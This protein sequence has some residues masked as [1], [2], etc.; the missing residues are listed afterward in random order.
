MTLNI[1][2][3]RRDTPGC[4]GDLI[5]LNNAGA[6]LMPAPV[7]AAV[8]DHLDLEARIG[9]YE[10]IE[11]RDGAFRDV[12]AAIAAL[13]NGAPDEIALVHNATEAWNAGFY[14][15]PWQ[16]GD[17]VIT[18]T[19]DY[20]SNMIAFRQL[21][22][23]RGVEVILAPE[24]ADASIDLEALPRLI[25][26]K[27]RLIAISHMPTNDGLVQPVAEIG[28]IARA[29]QVPFLLD[30]CQSVGQMP[31]D[32]ARLGCTMLSAT[33]RKYLRGPRGTGFLWMDRGQIARTMPH[34]LD[35]KAATWDRVDGFTL[36]PDARRFELWEKN[37]AGMLGLGAAC[38]YAMGLGLVPIRARVQ[39]LA[40]R[41]RRDL[42]ALPGIAVH[43][44]GQVQSGIVTFTRD[45]SDAATVIARLRRDHRINTSQSA[46]QLTRAA[47]SGARCPDMIRASVHYY[48]TEAEI[49]ALIAALGG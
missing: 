48:N 6:G 17:Q 26:P 12:Y 39:A 33:G 4:A 35:M 28:V 32:V 1:T 47:E 37:F 3:L 41:M 5:H 40:D 25:G 30:A 24:A 18:A 14:S 27:T 7:L 36:A 10:A 23:T 42:A 21:E 19:T 49:A 46:M 31:L 43:D 29:H 11:A 44:R 38:R 8:Q 45:G 16:A 34:I 20:A 22:H 13:I 9:G 15:I 2:E